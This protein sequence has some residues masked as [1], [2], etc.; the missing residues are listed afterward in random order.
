MLDED[1]LAKHGKLMDYIK[2]FE[3]LPKIEAYMKSDR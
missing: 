1:V 2:R 3:K